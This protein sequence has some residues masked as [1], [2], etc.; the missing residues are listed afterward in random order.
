MHDIHDWSK[1]LSELYRC[2]RPGGWVE[3][4]EMGGEL[5]SDDGTLADNHPTKRCWD[6]LTAAL[7][8]TGREPATGTLLNNILSAAGF[9][10]IEVVAVKQPI[11]LWP[12]DKRLKTIGKMGMLNIQLGT[13]AYCMAA[14]TR[15]L[16]LSVE[17][18]RE[19]CRDG[20]AA[21]CDPGVHMYNFFY[22]AYARKPKRKDDDHDEA[23]DSVDADYDSDDEAWEDET[24][25]G[26]GLEVH[27]TPLSARPA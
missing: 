7:R 14:L 9:E 12:H 20:V 18:A 21:V 3:I 15:I 8:A 17:A 10:E 26:Q 6:L 1:L 5:L 13:E 4:A 27:H 19:I 16:K 11:G 22:I 24:A 25:F 2:T 23:T